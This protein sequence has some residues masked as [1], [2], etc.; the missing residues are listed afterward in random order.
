MAAKAERTFQPLHEE[1]RAAVDT[2]CAAF[3]LSRS[4]QTLR[5]WACLETGPI[6]PIRVNGRLGWPVA[7]LKILLGVQ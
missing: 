1:K 4:T 6:R 7:D 5:K 2:A 3:H